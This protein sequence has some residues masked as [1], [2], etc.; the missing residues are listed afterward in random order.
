MRNVRAGSALFLIL[1]G[2]TQAMAAAL[3][4]APTGLDLPASQRTGTISLTNQA[5]SALNIQVRLFQWTQ[6]DGQDRLQPT[7]NVIASPPAT[8]VPPGQTYTIRVARLAAMPVSREE[9]YRLLI[10][11]LPSAEDEKTGNGITMLL[12]TSLPVFFHA[13]G[14]QA[15]VSWRVSLSDGLLQVEGRNL[16][17]RHVKLVNLAVEGDGGTQVSFGHGLNGYLLPG[18]TRQFTKRLS[19]SERLAFNA[20]KPVLLTGEMGKNTL[21]T[22]VNVAP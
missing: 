1:I 4:V 10:D 8:R 2:C 19:P 22:T 15:D 20:R 3:G 5:S 11:E 7:R 18:S 12:R 21:R 14:L 6:V 17:Q 9:S 16:G 13:P